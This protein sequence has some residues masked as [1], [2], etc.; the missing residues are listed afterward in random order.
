M[1]EKISQYTADGTSNPIQAEDYLDFSN[2]DGV[3]AYDVSKKI[4]VSE[5]IA[6]INSNV[7]NIYNS[8]GTLS[9]DR[10]V[11]AATNYTRWTGGDIINR[12]ADEV[13]DYAFLIQDSSSGEKGR[14]GYDQATVSG[15]LSLSNISG[16]FFTANDGVLAVNTNILYADADNV[17]IGTNTPNA[18]LRCEIRGASSGAGDYALATYN[19]SGVNGF[20]HRNDGY[21]GLRAGVPTGL[22]EQIGAQGQMF[23]YNGGLLIS[24]GN[25]Y[26]NIYADLNSG[27]GT[28]G[29]TFA[30]QAGANTN[31]KNFIVLNNEDGEYFTVTSSGGT[32]RV[33]INQ[34]SPNVAA[35]LDLTSTDKGLLIPRMTAAQASAITALNGLM[36]Y[37]T[38]TNGTFTSVGFWGY[39]AGAWTKL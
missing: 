5:L 1:A 36:L 9:E 37:V 21:I 27:L 20:A 16:E 31:T 32:G 23:V 12:M 14:L 11:T 4:L 34:P 18:A 17:G 8:N 25:G 7:D 22:G 29:S 2:Y 10:E 6:Y 26:S 33:G 28:T 30:L 13:S 24:S 19:S 15:H 3:S 39:E 38:D 35:I